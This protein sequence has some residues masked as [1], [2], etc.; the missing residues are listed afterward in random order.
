[1]DEPYYNVKCA[2]MPDKCKHLFEL[3]MA[4][5]EVKEGDDF[6]EE[7]KDFLKTKRT[8]KDFCVGLRVPGKLLPKRIRGGVLL[9]DTTYEMR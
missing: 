8:I 2:G 1:M 7:E 4:G 9:V 6:T 3:S 5:Y